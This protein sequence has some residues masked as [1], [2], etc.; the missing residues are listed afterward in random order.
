MVCSLEKAFRQTR[1][2]VCI[3]HET[4]LDENNFTALS[5]EPGTRSGLYQTGRGESGIGTA[6][7]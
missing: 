4:A 5:T 7:G 6:V 2:V 1:G 3:S